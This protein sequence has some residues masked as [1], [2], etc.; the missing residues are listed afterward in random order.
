MLLVVIL[1]VGP[2]Q[3][4]LFGG[5]LV[6]NALVGIVQGLRASGRWSGLPS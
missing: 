3:D 6:A 2:I 4:A 5:V 1:V